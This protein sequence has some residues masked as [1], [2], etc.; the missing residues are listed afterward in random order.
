MANTLKTVDGHHVN[1]IILAQKMY[2]QAQNYK[3]WGHFV[4]KDSYTPPGGKPVTPNGSIRAGEVSNQP[5][6]IH[7]ELVNKQGVEIKIPTLRNLIDRPKVGSET[8]KGYEEKQKMNWANVLVS[9][10]RSG[11]ELKDG[12]IGDQVTKEFTLQSKAKGQLLRHYAEVVNYLQL[13]H[14]L[15]YG[16]DWS[17]LYSDT[18]SGSTNITVAARSHPHIFTVGGGKVT[19]YPPTAAYETAVATAI[20]NIGVNHVLTAGWLR[21][22]AAEDNIR[23]IRPLYTK[24]GVPYKILALH[25]YQLKDLKNDKDL[26]A[27]YDSVFTQGMAARN[28]YLSN[29]QIYAEGFAIFDM[30]NSVWPA[31]T[32]S[33]VPM[34]GPT[35]IDDVDNLD[36][37]AFNSFSAFSKFTGVVLGDNALLKA[38]AQAMKFT[39]EVD[40]H[41]FWEAL[42]YT[43]VEGASRNDSINRDEGTAGDALINDGSAIIIT[44]ASAANL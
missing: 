17:T 38:S 12:P 3:G 21:E 10:Y 26:K 5:V 34:F 18:Y 31:W 20:D 40:D 39:T 6:V 33:G 32:A 8:L 9:V 37:S 14:A 44:A 2:F 11:V 42:G 1:P 22:L 29:M 24:D 13:A 36:M 15:Y 25:H 43:I 27:T 35:Y 30:G 4:S 19:G 7:R 23:R 28:P 41:D 16:Y